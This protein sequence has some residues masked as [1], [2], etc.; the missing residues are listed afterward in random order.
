[1]TAIHATNPFAEVPLPAGAVLVSDWYDEDEPMS[2][3][4]ATCR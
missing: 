1:M 3:P 2:A 4:P